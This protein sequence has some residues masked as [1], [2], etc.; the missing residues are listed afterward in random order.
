M[1][2]L[3][4]RRTA[5]IN[6]LPIDSRILPEIFRFGHVKGVARLF[7]IIEMSLATI[8]MLAT[9]LLVLLRFLNQ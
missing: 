5:T 6:W 8:T 2:K 9:L 7:L 4:R 3:R 1:K